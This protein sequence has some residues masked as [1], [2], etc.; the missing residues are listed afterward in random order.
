MPSLTR[1]PSYIYTMLVKETERVEE[2]SYVVAPL[3]LLC[4]ATSQNSL[5]NPRSKG[6]AQSTAMLLNFV[7]VIDGIG[8][9]RVTTL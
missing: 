2:H 9:S 5:R 6:L 7:V 4:L 1:T 8:K 3:E